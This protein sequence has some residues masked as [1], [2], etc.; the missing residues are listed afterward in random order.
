MKPPM[1]H[2]RG[3]CCAVLSH[4]P[5]NSGGCSSSMSTERLVALGSSWNISN[6]EVFNLDRYAWQDMPPM[7][8]TREL[9]TA[10]V[11]SLQ[12]EF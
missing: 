7:K 6:V 12:F 8:E 2:T 11:S 1:K 5:D 9:C 10:V 3:G 4:I